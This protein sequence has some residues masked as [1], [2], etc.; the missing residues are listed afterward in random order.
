MPAKTVK[1]SNRK[2]KASVESDP[3]SVHDHVD[4]EI[5]KL[6]KMSLAMHNIDPKKM[7]IEWKTTIKSD[8]YESYTLVDLET[9]NVLT[10]LCLGMISYVD[11][12]S[13]SQSLSCLT[14]F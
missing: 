12:T 9:K 4:V 8:Q 7:K 11:L 1:M 10:F 5:D 2:R 14:N 13:N 3:S 6:H